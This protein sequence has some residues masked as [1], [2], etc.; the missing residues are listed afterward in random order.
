[1]SVR[2]GKDN[3]KSILRA[4]KTVS[5]EKQQTEK[6]LRIF[7]VS[8]FNEING[9]NDMHGMYYNSISACRAVAA[10]NRQPNRLNGIA[11]DNNDQ[12]PQRVCTLPGR[13]YLFAHMCFNDSA[14]AIKSNIF[15]IDIKH[16]NTSNNNFL[17]NDNI[18]EMPFDFGG[19]HM[20]HSGFDDATTA[21]H[22]S[23]SVSLSGFVENSMEL[24]CA[25]RTSRPT[26]KSH[27]KAT[28]EKPPQVACVYQCSDESE[29]APVCTVD[30]VKT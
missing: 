13:A 12:K 23:H 24:R 11:T 7:L 29:R 6:K 5:K 18:S 27:T 28:L 26:A 19:H 30:A 1:M 17:L 3:R 16:G 2:K 4:K 15:S 10:S 22:F 20:P 8:S 25:E 14:L 9:A 21:T